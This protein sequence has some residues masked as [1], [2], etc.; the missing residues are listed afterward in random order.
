MIISFSEISLVEGGALA[1]F[2]DGDKNLSASAKAVDAACDGALSRAVEGSNFRGK[3]G[4]KL[5]IIGPAGGPSRIVLLGTGKGEELAADKV[6]EI[7]GALIAHLQASGES[8][9]NVAVDDVAGCELTNAQIAARMAAGIRVRSYRF[10][11]YRT[12]EPEHKKPTVKEVCVMCAASD[13][14]AA[15]YKPIDHV[16][17]G[18]FLTRDVISE[19]A[20]VIYPESYAERIKELE[21]DGIE[22][23]ILGEPELEKLGMG[24]L[25]GVGQGSARASR[26]VIMRWNGS[27][28]GPD[29]QPIS[30]VG[31]GVTFDTGGISLKPGEGMEE[32]KWD[33]GG[34]GI[35]VGTMRGLARRKAKVNVVGVVG[36]VEN[37]PSS[38]AQRPSDVVTSM[39]GQTIEIINTDAEGR[40]VLADAI[41]YTQDR[42][43]PKF[44][45]DLATLTGAMLITLGRDQYSGFFTDDDELAAQ[46]SAAGELSGDRCWR[47]PLTG[48][49]DSMIDS[50]IADMKNASGRMAG[51]ITAAQFLKRF[52]NK[53]P[54]VHIDV[55]G[56]V[57]SLK[58]NKKWEKGATGYGV[59]LLDR[60]VADNYEAK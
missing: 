24:A 39:S 41:W 22:V 15:A 1:L 19:P 18:V 12:K 60:F 10:D 54:W 23:E 21:A 55:A 34:S 7:G 28:D 8:K 50:D 42:F 20:N 56:V 2:A 26:L 47:L 25:L 9:I 32:M 57:W 43:K 46:L 48:E 38:T 58:S 44:M 13:E 17:D 31:K 45:I 11:K 51:S 3:R 37:M 30:F 6:E 49:Y 35:V 4:D 27:P 5:E 14:A 36:L 16:I 59:R 40:L 29:A 52:T 33:M 53:V